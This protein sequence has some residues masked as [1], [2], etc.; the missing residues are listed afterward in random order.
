LISGINY[1]IYNVVSINLYCFNVD[2]HIELN[3]F[4]KKNLGMVLNNSYR[5]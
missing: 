5:L 4:L 1:I 3:I 2:L